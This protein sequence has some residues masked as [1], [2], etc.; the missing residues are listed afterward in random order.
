MSRWNRRSLLTLSAVGIVLV[1]L[2]AIIS[3]RAVEHRT[4]ASTTPSAAP[5]ATPYLRGVPMN[6]LAHANLTLGPPTGPK[7]VV[8]RE[9]AITVA[10]TSEPNRQILDASYLH[11]T[12]PGEKEG[13]D[14]W[15]V[16]V[17]AGDQQSGPVGSTHHG[18]G[19]Y[20]FVLVDGA[21][22]QVLTTVEGN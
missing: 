5:T 12:N 18:V 9:Q 10:T 21:T 6:D 22:G 2:I 14:E 7:P 13:R 4:T 8:S 1:M 20:R 16:A 17:T 3:T 11:F 15:V 19:T